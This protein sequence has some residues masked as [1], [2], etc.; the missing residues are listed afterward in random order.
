[1]QAST[2]L[3]EIKQVL[4]QTPETVQGVTEFKQ[5]MTEFAETECG[6]S[7]LAP[8]KPC[9]EFDELLGRTASGDAKAQLT[10]LARAHPDITSRSEA[11]T[12]IADVLESTRERRHFVLYSGLI[13]LLALCSLLIAVD[14][15]SGIIA[16]TIVA[17]CSGFVSAI[18]APSPPA[19]DR[20]RFEDLFGANSV[21]SVDRDKKKWWKGDV[22]VKFKLRCPGLAAPNSS[23][24]PLND[25]VFV[26]LRKEHYFL[27]TPDTE[28]GNIEDDPMLFLSIWLSSNKDPLVG[29]AYSTTAQTPPNLYPMPLERIIDLNNIPNTDEAAAKFIEDVRTFLDQ[30]TYYV[31]LREN[32][33]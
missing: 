19:F 2:F 4:A 26:T 20:E 1:M 11:V 3:Q 17:L 32:H 18:R 21:T 30:S 9:S 27:T 28:T 31:L 7:T 12:L 15:Y 13:T 33:E 22:W 8:E 24:I 6:R 23:R 5:R 14:L 25:K 29:T 10:Q 16:A